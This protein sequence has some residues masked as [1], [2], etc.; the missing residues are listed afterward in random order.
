MLD[1]IKPNR[2]NET[3]LSRVVHHMENH[4]CGT[5]TA[6]RSKEG[7]GGTGR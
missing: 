7:C 3:S 4:D 6:F 2:L 1:K 5:I